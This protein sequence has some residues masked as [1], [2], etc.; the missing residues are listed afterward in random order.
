MV[1]GNVER[2]G[3]RWDFS[4][5]EKALR[6]STEWPLRAKSAIMEFQEWTLATSTYLLN[7]DVMFGEVLKERNKFFILVYAE[8]NYKFI[9]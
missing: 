8:T 2:L 7:C 5:E 4:M 3:L 9:R 6:A 1:Q